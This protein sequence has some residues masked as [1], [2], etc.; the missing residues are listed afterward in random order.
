MAKPVSRKILIGVC[1]ILAVLALG[2]ARA[3]VFAQSSGLQIFSKSVLEI[4]TT[5]GKI[6]F[7]IEIARTPRQQAQG[8]MFRRRLAADA[9]MLFLYD[10]PQIIRMWMKN[11]F[12]PLDMIF[13]G[14]DGRIVSIAQRTI[15][16]SL[17]TVS[18]ERLASAVLEVNGGTATRLGIRVGDRI[19]HASIGTGINTGGK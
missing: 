11:T 18:S 10:Q 5:V 14:K 6:K 9:G 3:P 8:L 1:G 15:P 19:N 12:I 2:G 17:E 7:S 4:A 16:K 13:I